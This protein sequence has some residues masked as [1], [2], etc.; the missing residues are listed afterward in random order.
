[1]PHSAVPS[2]KPADAAAAF[3]ARRSS[4]PTAPDKPPSDDAKDRPIPPGGASDEFA[5]SAGMEKGAGKV[6]NIGVEHIASVFEKAMGD[7]DLFLP[8]APDNCHIAL[9]KSDGWGLPLTLHLDADLARSNKRVRG[10]AGDIQ[11]LTESSNAGTPLPIQLIAK[12]PFATAADKAA[13]NVSSARTRLPIHSAPLSSS[14]T[15]VFLGDQRAGAIDAPRSDKY[16]S[17]CLFAWIRAESHFSTQMA[18]YNLGAGIA[19]GSIMLMPNMLRKLPLL[20]DDSLG[21][22]RIR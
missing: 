9:A 5:L 15:H 10:F 7:I 4:A 13:Q 18:F 6:L 14:D 1:M 8:T 3:V 22:L 12:V 17:A 11:N 21:L 2:P 20:V 19:P 16:N